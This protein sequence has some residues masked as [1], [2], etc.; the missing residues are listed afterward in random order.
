MFQD[1]IIEEIHETRRQIWAEC[2]K[3]H[4]ELLARLR[5]MEEQ[6]KDRLVRGKPK[7]ALRSVKQA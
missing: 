1:P 4:D 5:K 2:R 3:N 6:Y 7:P